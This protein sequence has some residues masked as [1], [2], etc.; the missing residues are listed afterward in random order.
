MAYLVIEPSVRTHS[1]ILKA[2]P[3]ASW[4]WLCALGHAQEGLT[5][6]VVATESLPFL[7]VKDYKKLSKILVKVGLFDVI[8]GGFQIHD[9][10]EHNKSA[11]QIR[12]E[13]RL[14]RE[15]G[16]AGAKFGALGGRPPRNPSEGLRRNPLSSPIL[17]S[18][19]LPPSED[20][21]E[22]TAPPS[23]PEP[24]VLTFDE[25][26]G[27]QKHWALTQRNL[28]LYQ[29][30]YPH[31]DVLAEVRKALV[32]LHTNPSRRKTAR[33]MAAFVTGWLN[34]AQDSRKGQQVNS[35][36][37]PMQARQSSSSW[38]EGELGALLER[39]GLNRYTLATW[40]EGARLEGDTLVL[41]DAQKLAWVKHSYATTLAEA[42]T[43][44]TPL[45]LSA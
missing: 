28:E 20:C 3:A 9:Y 44:E 10:L 16:K 30:G 26:A 35:G 32:W 42:W 17:S 5:D 33:G 25:C 41:S 8:P 12:D 18:P 31:L 6:G 29:D 14:R 34:R 21:A 4:L 15:G 11:Q 39:T 36:H 38:E 45:R 27:K 13:M 40:F 19:I 24:A 23:T 37:R 22:V 1:K 43:G 7:G 2:G